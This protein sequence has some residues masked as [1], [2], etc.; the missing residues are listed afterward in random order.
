MGNRD[1]RGFCVGIVSQEDVTAHLTEI[2]FF[3]ALVVFPINTMYVLANPL[4]TFSRN[5]LKIIPC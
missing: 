2:P 5:I 1:W 3:L 4:Y